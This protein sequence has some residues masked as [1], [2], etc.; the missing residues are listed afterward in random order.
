MLQLSK[1]AGTGLPQ[2]ELVYYHHEQE[3]KQTW[4]LINQNRNFFDRLKDESET[5]IP[6][7]EL[8]EA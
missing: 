3:S 6:Y 8:L 4:E 2:L 1:L 5:L 7:E